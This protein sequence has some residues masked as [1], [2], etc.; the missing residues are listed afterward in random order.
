M[1]S[2]I[3]TLVPAHP[4]E[5]E[6]AVIS[7]M[8]LLV[9]PNKDLFHRCQKYFGV[10]KPWSGREVKNNWRHLDFKLHMHFSYILAELFK[11][12]KSRHLLCG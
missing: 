2:K 10:I 6:I 7:S 9:I 11:L 5:G 8:L 3:I 4:T 1:F 12:N